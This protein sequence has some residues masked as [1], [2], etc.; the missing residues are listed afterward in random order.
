MT[1]RTLLKLLV[2]V[3]L[4]GPGIAKA[5]AKSIL[6]PLPGFTPYLPAEFPRWNAATD[7]LEDA[8]RW[9]LNIE[10]SRLPQDTLFPQAGQVWEAVRD[11]DVGFRANLNFCQSPPGASG[12]RKAV[13][14]ALGPAAV[15]TG[16][17]G[18][19]VVLPPAPSP[20][21]RGSFIVSG[22]TARLTRGERVCILEGDGAP[23]IFVTF[24]PV[25]YQE[26]HRVIVP[27]D[28][29]KMPEYRG[30]VLSLKTA[31]T[32]SDEALD[33][34]SRPTLFLEAF[35]RVLV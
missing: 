26:L 15:P 22:G 23:P 11:C 27:E 25:R 10:R 5:L 3:P 8:G 12:L 19:L 18:C 9:A 24:Q 31:R 1:R 14:A 20:R 17:L 4:V 28:I 29:R 13:E 21:A 2:L 32:I 7:G 6:K 30:Y 16:K 33:R 34:K 35:K